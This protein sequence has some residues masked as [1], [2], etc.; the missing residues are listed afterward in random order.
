MEQNEKERRA[1]GNKI[2]GT[3]YCTKCTHRIF[4]GELKADEDSFEW[5]NES[6]SLHDGAIGPH[7][8]ECGAPMDYDEAA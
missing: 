1:F 4:P 2:I 5:S 6:K 7:C 8:K 3:W